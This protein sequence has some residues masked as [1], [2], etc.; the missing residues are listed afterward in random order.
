MKP[1]ESVAVHQHFHKKAMAALNTGRAQAI[2]ATARL[3]GRERRTS[4]VTKETSNGLAN[5]QAEADAAVKKV[6]EQNIDTAAGGGSKGKLYTY[7]FASKPLGISL[8]HSKEHGVGVS[9]VKNKELPVE[10]I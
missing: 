9:M 4:E 8:H 10:V 1:K 2:K 5:A 7:D 3:R 6:M